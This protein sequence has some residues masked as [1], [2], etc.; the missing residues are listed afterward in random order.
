MLER[1]QETL[2]LEEAV[3]DLRKAKESLSKQKENLG[4]KE[5]LSLIHI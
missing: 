2:R 1:D 5:N 3:N 4:E